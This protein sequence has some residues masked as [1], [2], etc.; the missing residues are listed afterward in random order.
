MSR[1]NVAL[2]AIAFAA[3]FAL[4]AVLTSR[5]L[6]PLQAAPPMPAFGAISVQGT[7]LTVQPLPAGPEPRVIH[8][9]SRTDALAAEKLLREALQW[10]DPKVRVMAPAPA[11]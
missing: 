3:C 2:G 1:S 4:L 6:Q 7:D 5:P 10:A 11:P 9:S 8:F